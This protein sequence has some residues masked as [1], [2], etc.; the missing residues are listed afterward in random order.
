MLKLPRHYRYTFFFIC[1][2]IHNFTNAQTNVVGLITDVKNEPIPYTN[3]VLK[4]SDSLASIIAYTYAENNGKYNLEI[5]KTGDF[6]L[7]ISSLGYEQKI[8]PIQI[9]GIT[10]EVTKNVSLIERTFELDEIIIQNELPIKVGRDTITFNVQK[11]IRGNETVIEDLL[12]NL[13]GVNVDVDGK[14]TI[15][16]QEIEKLMVDGDDLFEKGYTIL[17]KNLPVHPVETV[18]ILK[19]YSNNRLLKEI[20]SSNKVAVNLKLKE[21]AKNIWFGNVTLG[22]DIEFNSRYNVKGN[23]ANFGKKNKY[24]FLTNLNNTG[25]DAT[26]DINQLIKPIRFN[27]PGS[28]GDDQRIFNLNNLSS[29][30]PNFMPGRTNFNNAELVSLNAIFNITDKIKLKTLAF[31]NSDENDFFRNSTENF[32]S[33]QTNFTNSEDFVLRKRKQTGFGKIDLIHNI[34]K[35]KSLEI[36]TK[37]N[38]RNQDSRSDLIFNNISTIQELGTANTLFDQKI[39]YTNRFKEKKVFIL[40]GR[41]INEKSPQ[42]YNIN[43]FFYQDLF[44]EIDNADSVS[45]LS[46]NKYRFAGF[47]SHLLDRKKNGNLFELKVGNEIRIDDLKS[48]FSVYDQN[49]LIEQPEGFQNNLKYTTNDFYFKCKYLLKINEFGF[50]GNLEF[51]QL[52]NKIQFIDN[53]INEV[54]FFINPGFRIN[55]KINS[56]NEINTSLSYNATNADVL[57]T[58]NNFSLTGFRSFSQGTGSFNQ[59][60]ASNYFINYRLGDWGD[61]FFASATVSY[62]KNND[63]FST[64]SLISQDFSLSEQI[65]I[66]DSEFFNSSSNIDYYFKHI[67]SNLKLNLGY[68]KSR[69]SNIVNESDFREVN[70][71]NNNYG[72]KLRSG[73]KGVF[74]YHFG[75]EWTFNKIDVGEF[76]N[77]FTDNVSFLDLTF[78]FNDKFNFDLKSERYYFGNLQSNNIFYFLDVNA[79]YMVKKNKMTLFLDARNLF[80][81]RRFQ[82]FSISDISSS[83]TEYRLLPRYVLLKL[84][85]RF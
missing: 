80:N 36:T 8:I 38:K 33:N 14:I 13:P 69:L 70:S 18:E 44:P 75:T 4:A 85:Y 74:N 46:E 79:R 32:N 34:S 12:K 51:H 23:L 63:F 31:F 2:I 45:Q 3:I 59:L 7:V 26:G 41:Y 35:T 71:S 84:E 25:D 6:N 54:P 83:T 61:R 62:T 82:N 47:E 52:F 17:S 67:K 21:G 5:D 68:S 10:K 58:T 72:L 42:A 30:V 9:D 43:Q 65:I 19:N 78:A 66:N 77:S 50:E 56:K 16:N 81:T 37:Y 15:G 64:N 57:S 49:I 29:Y 28:I 11:F 1:S 20:E 76:G 60:R 27:E 73:F 40:T 53:D 48:I 24:Y 39:S 22:Y 55:W